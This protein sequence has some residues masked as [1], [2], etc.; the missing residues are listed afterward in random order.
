MSR[1]YLATDALVS[2]DGLYRY[3]LARRLS[4]GERSVAFVGLN[5]STADAA[6]DDPTIRKCA[7][8]AARWGFDWL[9][10]VNLYAWRATDPKRMLAFAKNYEGQAVG[11]DNDQHLSWVTGRCELVVPAWGAA[12]LTP[13][14]KRLSQKILALPHAKAL[15]LTQ[16]GQPW[17]P[18]YVPYETELVAV[19]AQGKAGDREDR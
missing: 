6:K 5:P 17:H 11:F 14:A 18:L 4:M 3:W 13:Y 10:M 9:Y 1:K 8:F 2:D 7:G 16:E 19:A 12:K 15:R